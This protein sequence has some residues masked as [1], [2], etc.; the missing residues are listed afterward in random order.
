M[1]EL[2][3]LHRI[4]THRVEALLDAAFGTDRRAKTAYKLREGVAAIQELSFAAMDG[5]T[6]VGTIQCWPIA[7]EGPE[8]GLS[9]MKLVGPVAVRPDLQ[10]S[11][12]G[13]VMMAHTLAV[14]DANG[15]D[16]LIMIGDP[17]YYERFFGFTAAPTQEWD[18][19][20]PFERHRLL[21]RTNRVGGLPVL[22][23][24]IPDPAFARAGATA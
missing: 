10:R 2:I 4:E 9:P 8:C 3:P 20:G 7:L 14:A 1:V 18:L 19:P 22:G 17:E 15:Q 6:L 21:A 11:G 5:E 16:A 12:V 13:K 24:I 23:T